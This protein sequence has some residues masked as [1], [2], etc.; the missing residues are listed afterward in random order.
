VTSTPRQEPSDAFT[1]CGVTDC[2]S[3]NVPSGL[4]MVVEYAVRSP[5]TSTGSP[6]AAACSDA[7]T[8][9]VLAA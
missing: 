3:V 2:V 7:D 9:S 6:E 8:V 4:A 5:V 1:R